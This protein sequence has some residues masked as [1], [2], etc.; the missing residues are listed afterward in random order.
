MIGIDFMINKDSSRKQGGGDGDPKLSKA[1]L[2]EL[3]LDGLKGAGLSEAGLK[4]LNFKELHGLALKV[5]NRNR[6]FPSLVIRMFNAVATEDPKRIKEFTGIISEYKGVKNYLMS[7]ITHMGIDNPFK[8]TRDARIVILPKNEKK[9]IGASGRMLKGTMYATYNPERPNETFG[10]ATG[11]QGLVRIFSEFNKERGLSLNPKPRPRTDNNIRAALKLI[12]LQDITLEELTENPQLA[13][14]SELITRNLEVYEALRKAIDNYK[15]QLSSLLYG[16]SIALQTLES[17]RVD[18]DPG[19]Q[20]FGWFEEHFKETPNAPIGLK[21]AYQSLIDSTV[22]LSENDEKNYLR[23]LLAYKR[24]QTFIKTAPA[25][26]GMK[27]DIEAYEALSAEHPLSDK[28]P[29]IAQAKIT[30]QSVQGKTELSI[31]EYS[32]LLEQTDL[33]NF[34]AAMNALSIEQYGADFYTA[35]RKFEF[36][37]LAKDGAWRADATTDSAPMKRLKQHLYGAKIGVEH[38]SD[39]DD[40]KRAL[41]SDVDFRAIMDGEIMV[42]LLGSPDSYL[43]SRPV[44]EFQQIVERVVVAYRKACLLDKK[45]ESH[46]AAQQGQ[47]INFDPENVGDALKDWKPVLPFATETE[48]YRPVEHFPAATNLGLKEIARRLSDGF[49]AIKDNRNS[50]NE[51]IKTNSYDLSRQT[52]E[53]FV[54]AGLY[55]EKMGDVWLAAER[56]VAAYIPK[57]QL[58]AGV[59]DKATK[60]LIHPL[61]VLKEGTYSSPQQLVNRR[62]LSPEENRKL[63]SFVELVDKLE[64]PEM[65]DDASSW[66][67]LRRQIDEVLFLDVF[68]ASLGKDKML[69]LESKRVIDIVASQQRQSGFMSVWVINPTRMN[70]WIAEGAPKC[71]ISENP[72][73]QWRNKLGQIMRN[74]NWPLVGRKEIAS[75]SWNVWNKISSHNRSLVAKQMIRLID[76]L[77]R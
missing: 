45:L 23:G 56:E 59:V 15:Q 31:Q 40:K 1:K 35:L 10:H 72:N 2:K 44:K 55:Q 5:E 33:V 32:T 54:E 21:I 68:K 25:L 65:G 43:K 9:A 60:Y 47:A 28:F 77:V 74:S 49:L 62:Y 12:D 17:V 30:L 73:E 29:N 26:R 67:E 58:E 20:F 70:K 36:V 66:S 16:D 46:K 13:E 4:K 37:V 76:D 51:L 38:Q 19:R 24:T 8:A 64:L 27:E 18:G 71:Q 11:I 6:P 52:S 61:L 22:H 14:Q 75:E 50:P 7:F 63:G 57:E 53:G 42:Q 39:A 69:L 3:R 48:R 41:L 34:R